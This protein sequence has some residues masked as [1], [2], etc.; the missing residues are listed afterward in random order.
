M[1]ERAK[2][3]VFA[4]LYA[5]SAIGLIYCCG[6]C[7]WRV[8]AVPSQ[9]RVLFVLLVAFGGYGAWLCAQTAVEI[10]QSVLKRVDDETG[11]S[12][13]SSQSQG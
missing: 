1:Y 5:L 10:A 6:V 9:S 12:E 11:K 8:S 13:S 7:L 3:S 2:E 4:V